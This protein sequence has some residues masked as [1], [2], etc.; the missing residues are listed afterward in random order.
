MSIGL[1][2]YRLA[3]GARPGARPETGRAAADR[4]RRLWI[5]GEAR[6]DDG[7]PALGLARA[8]AARRP[9]LE[10]LL[11]EAGAVARLP[12]AG[13][14]AIGLHPAGRGVRDATAFLDQAKPGL[15]I[16]LGG[17]LDPGLI[18][19][20]QARGVPLVLAGAEAAA[21]S[22]APAAADGALAR[23]VWALFPGIA[24][25]LLRPFHRVLAA[26]AAAARALVRLG[27]APEAT[28][29]TG[30]LEHPSLHGR[31]NP[32]ERAAL[33]RQFGSRPLWVAL[34]ARL[35]EADALARAHLGAMRAAHRLLL[36]AV[37]A[38]PD[39]GAILRQRLA[40]RGLVVA[41][42]SLDQDPDEEVQ[43]YI[44]DTE[45]EAALWL[46]L[47]PIA[48]M[49][50]TLGLG[51]APTV[52][53]RPASQQGGTHPLM[54]VSHG[55]VVLHG[56]HPPAHGT[57]YQRLGRAGAAWQVTDA[58][59]IATA[60]EALLAPTEAARRAAAGWEVASAGAAT[61]R[62]LLELVD[63]IMPAGGP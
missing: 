41:Q 57:I 45:G 7:A 31:V 15:G 26:D 37:P 8:I 9:D 17:P 11:R 44:A 63:E 24:R 33:A 60:I 28:E 1:G 40:A 53:A 38:A 22:F 18:A 16:L 19:A 36:I 46:D 61:T 21:A 42:R 59:S 29:A 5:E 2:L 54:A 49:G 62:R 34:D 51:A 47:A 52:G 55:A 48:F 35:A 23:A 32:A 4:P 30:P 25:G 13:A 6:A 39:S 14:G 12:A 50:G 20:A 43:A 3:L 56:P 27:A 10:V 58:A